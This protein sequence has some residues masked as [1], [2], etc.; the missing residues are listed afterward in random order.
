MRKASGNAF[1]LVLFGSENDQFE[2]A[3]D[4]E[5]MRFT[6][7]ATGPT[8]G[9]Q[10]GTPPVELKGGGPW[11]DAVA[12]GKHTLLID[13]TDTPLQAALENADVATILAVLDPSDT[14]EES[15]AHS[16]RRQYGSLPWRAAVR[17]RRQLFWEFCRFL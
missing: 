1:D 2:S 14:I 6:V 9:G 5:L 4:T 3:N 10:T 12:D 15:D 8:G 17:F 16:F 13:P 11:A 7:A